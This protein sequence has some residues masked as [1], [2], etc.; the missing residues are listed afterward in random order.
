MQTIL[1]L[2]S[3]LQAASA[4]SLVMPENRARHSFMSALMI[5]SVK[6][7]ALVRNLDALARALAMR[8][9]ASCWVSSAPTW[10]IQ[11][12]PVLRA[13]A[14]CATGVSAALAMTLDLASSDMAVGA[15]VCA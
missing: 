12:E 14:G 8:S 11:S 7:F 13:T 3:V 9:L 2:L 4:S 5:G 6:D 15:G 1:A 10:I